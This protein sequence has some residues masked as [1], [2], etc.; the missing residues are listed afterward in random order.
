MRLHCFFIAARTP[1]PAQTELNAL[2]ASSRVLAVHREW[3]ND[4][5]Q[6]G[7]AFC[8]EVQPGQGPLPEAL[9]AGGGAERRR[10]T[11]IDYR[12]VLSEDDFAI[13]ARLRA[14]RKQL[15]QRD[16]VPLYAVCSN[17]QMAAMVTRRVESLPALAGIEGMGPARMERYGAALLAVLAASAGAAANRA[18]S[19]GPP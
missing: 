3:L 19:E 11:E 15:A 17:E 10:G 9:K 8:V 2:L 12:Q 13:Y 18:A 5:A 16:G 4:G 14:T 7:W 6:S 1:E